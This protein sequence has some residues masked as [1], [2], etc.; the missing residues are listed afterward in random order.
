V[1][2][3]DGQ[4]I[5]QGEAYQGV[6]ERHLDGGEQFAACSLFVMVLLVCCDSEQ[7]GTDSS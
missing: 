7:E 4:L 6:V 3:L 5:A 1:S 2:Q